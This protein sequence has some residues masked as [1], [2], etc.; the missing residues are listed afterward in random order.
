MIFLMGP[1]YNKNTPNTVKIVQKGFFTFEENYMRALT[2][3]REIYWES[4]RAPDRCI[5]FQR[6]PYRR[7]KLI[8]DMYGKTKEERK[9]TF[10]LYNAQMIKH[11][12]YREATLVEE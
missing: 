5:T 1:R 6:N 9:A 3:F 7:Q 8:K 12:E 2:T 10:K 11:K 4:L